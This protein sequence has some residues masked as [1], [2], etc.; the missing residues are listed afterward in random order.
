MR[1]EVVKVPGEMSNPLRSMRRVECRRFGE[2]RIWR[3]C[4]LA[5]GSSCAKSSSVERGIGGVDE[6]ERSCG[7]LPSSGVF[8]RVYECWSERV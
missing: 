3:W 4:N 2:T 5:I 6:R 7:A 1:C 8:G